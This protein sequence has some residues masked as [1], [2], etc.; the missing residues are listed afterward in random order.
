MKRSILF[1]FFL[2][3]AIISHAQITIDLGQIQSAQNVDLKCL[4]QDAKTGDAL[5]YTTVYL[6]PQGDTTITHFALSDE[7]G[8]VKIEGIV[9][10]IEGQNKPKPPNHV[11]SIHPSARMK[12]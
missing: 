3:S 11:C 10:F 7:K 2:T 5:P 12:R 6:I 1:L 8:A 9:I 4:I